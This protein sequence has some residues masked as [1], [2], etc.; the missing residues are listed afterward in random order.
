M[1]NEIKG[2]CPFCGAPDLEAIELM[3]YP[4][5]ENPENYSSEYVV[6]C[7]NCAANGPPAGTRAV[8][9]RQWNEAQER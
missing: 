1:G 7:Q 4:A 9:I 8:A 2:V 3:I 5:G 6:A